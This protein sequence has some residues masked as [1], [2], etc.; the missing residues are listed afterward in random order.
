MAWIIHLVEAYN[1]DDVIS[2]IGIARTIQAVLVIATYIGVH[3]PIFLLPH[4]DQRHNFKF[5]HSI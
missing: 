5:G 4:G 3:F 2:S 1:D